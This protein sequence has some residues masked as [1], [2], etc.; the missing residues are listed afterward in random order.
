LPGQFPPSRAVC[1]AVV[2]LSLLTISPSALSQVRP[3]KAYQDARNL[4]FNHEYAQAKKLLRT[5]LDQYPLNLDA[6]NLYGRVLAWDGDYEAALAQYDSVLKFIPD[7]FDATFGS[8]Q[9]YAW[10]GHYTES[11]VILEEL[12]ANHPSS[13]ELTLF[14]AHVL[15][16][17]G[18]PEQA[19][20]RYEDV[21]RMDPESEDAVRGL[22]RASVQ[23]GNFESGVGWYELLLKKAPHDVE[24]RN[25]IIRLSYRSANEVQILGSYESFVESG[26]SN[27]FIGGVEYYYS[28]SA[29]TKMY[30]HASTVSKF[31]ETDVRLG[32]G[33]YHSLTHSMALWA[34]VLMSPD[35]AVAP[36]FDALADITISPSW[37]ELILGYRYMRFG[38]ADIHTLVP[39]LSVYVLYGLWG[40]ARGYFS[41][42]TSAGNSRSGTFTI[43]Y[44]PHPLTTIRIGIFGGNEA[45]RATSIEEIASYDATGF[46]LSAKRRL[47]KLLAIDGTYQYSRRKP[48]SNSHALTVTLSLLF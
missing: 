35:A 36:K 3:D 27:H 44:K 33:V 26:Y 11:L 34:Y 15:L 22:A 45:F 28:V 7:D 16:W 38:G 39:G 47:T 41:Q 2:L 23:S 20:W 18:R 30:L 43:Y 12:R 40:T 5:L 17:S 32:G 19:L 37:W 48:G 31:G 14:V 21:Y 8:A 6:R 13:L 46:Y 9:V 24:A 25:E 42:S 29:A 10:T 4:A 1:S